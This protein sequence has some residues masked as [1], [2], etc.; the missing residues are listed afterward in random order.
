M[1]ID[2]QSCSKQKALQLEAINKP[3]SAWTEGEMWK[4][5]LQQSI[6]IFQKNKDWAMKG[7]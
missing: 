3:E 7:S 5:Q 2:V 6:L 4:L 1:P